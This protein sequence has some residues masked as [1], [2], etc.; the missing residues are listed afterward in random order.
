MGRDGAA[1][2]SRLKSAGAVTFAQDEASSQVFGMPKAA[3]KMDA[4]LHVRPPEEIR[5]ALDALMGTRRA[6]SASPRVA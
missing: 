5:Q 3:I 4:A 2:L 1:G 6:A